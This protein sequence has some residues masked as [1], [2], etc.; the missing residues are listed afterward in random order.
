[1]SSTGSILGND[2]SGSVISLELSGVNINLSKASLCNRVSYLL[3]RLPE[4]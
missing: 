2:F 3:S 1:M 4:E